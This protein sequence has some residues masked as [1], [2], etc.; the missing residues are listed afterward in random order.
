MYAFVCCISGRDVLCR[1]VFVTVVVSIEGRSLYFTSHSMRKEGEGPTKEEMK[2]GRGDK[3]I[4]YIASAHPLFTLGSYIVRLHKL[5]H[6]LRRYKETS[7][8]TIQPNREKNRRNMM[9]MTDFV[10]VIIRTL[11]T[12]ILWDNICRLYLLKIFAKR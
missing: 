3:I 6:H 5:L 10:V 8:D 11:S 9:T 2:K 4:V 12:K 7:A 1:V